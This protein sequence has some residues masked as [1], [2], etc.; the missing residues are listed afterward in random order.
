MVENV[1]GAEGVTF[2]RYD[3]ETN[4]FTDPTLEYL[5]SIGILNELPNEAVE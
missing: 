5:Y 1:P 2:G 4:T 3:P